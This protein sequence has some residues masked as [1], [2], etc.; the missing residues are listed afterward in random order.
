[1]PARPRHRTLTRRQITRLLDPELAARIQA[2]GLTPA[3]VR[4]W[5]TVQAAGQSPHR[6]GWALIARLYPDSDKARLAFALDGQ[7]CAEAVVF[8]DPNDHLA[9]NLA[10]G[11]ENALH[12]ANHLL[13]ARDQ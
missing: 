2:R 12:A 10:A 11:L 6:E 5:A 8:E 13:H 3:A 4:A 7:L 9:A 1:M